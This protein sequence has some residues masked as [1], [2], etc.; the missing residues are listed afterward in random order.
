MLKESLANTAITVHRVQ[1]E[2]SRVK[3]V[4]EVEQINAIYFAG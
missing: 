3:R 2:R 1:G 4:M